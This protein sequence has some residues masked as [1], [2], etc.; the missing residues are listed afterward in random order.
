[1]DFPINK[2]FVSAIQA[3]YKVDPGV[4]AAETYVCGEVLEHAAKAV[5]GKVE[6]KAALNKALHEAKLSDSLRGPMSFD[7]Y[8]NAVGNSTSVRWRRRATSSSMRS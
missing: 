5:G 1:L 4:Y 2:K 8:G 6:D 3:E 7:K